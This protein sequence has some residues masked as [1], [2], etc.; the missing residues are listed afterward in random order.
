MVFNCPIEICR[1]CA[2]SYVRTYL[3]KLWRCLFLILLMSLLDELCPIWATSLLP[4]LLNIF[5]G[6]VNTI[7]S[8]RRLN[9]CWGA[10]SDRIL[11]ME[12]FALICDYLVVFSG[13]AELPAMLDDF[14]C[15]GD[16]VSDNSM[17]RYHEVISFLIHKSLNTAT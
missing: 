16:T 9:I 13:M 11:R 5:T 7:I 10:Q 6:I 2:I 1:V 17:L 3:K 8:N 12:L 15:I 4:V 14:T